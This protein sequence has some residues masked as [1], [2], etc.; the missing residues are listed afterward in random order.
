MVDNK[1]QEDNPSESQQGQAKKETDSTVQFSELKENDKKE[2]QKDPNLNLNF[3]LDLVLQ[4]RVEL[5][6]T[7]MSIQDLLQLNAGS[8]I[9]LSKFASEPLE[10][11]VNDKEIAKG[12]VVVVNEKFGVRL[13]EIISPTERVKQL[14]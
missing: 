11:F 12:E 7:T 1:V 4:V 3:I 10:I 5:G 8:V 13:T 6:R 2:I 9:E 14:G